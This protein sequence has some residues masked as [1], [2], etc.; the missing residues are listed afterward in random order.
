MIDPS[1]WVCTI[2]EAEMRDW[3]KREWDLWMTASVNQDKAPEIAYA[4]A[5]ILTNW[6]RYKDV[7]MQLMPNPPPIMIATIG[8][9]HYRESTFNFTKN[10]LNGD[11][12][13][14]QTVNHP[15]GRPPGRPDTPNGYSWEYAAV[16]ALKYEEIDKIKNWTLATALATMVRWNGAGAE[17]YHNTDDPYLW[18][19]TN[20]YTKGKYA[21]DGHWD[22]NE[23]DEQAGCAAIFMG[24]KAQGLDLNEIPPP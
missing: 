24:L 12:L 23:M 16:D 20:K 13:T 7:A 6:L 9:F 10:L 18:S 2:E 22:A 5:R 19:F 21:S 17:L 11:P 15:A 4:S 14:K 3:P 1:A 8:C